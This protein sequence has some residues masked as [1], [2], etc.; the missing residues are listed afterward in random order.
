MALRNSGL[1]TMPAGFGFTGSLGSG[2]YSDPYDH[3]MRDQA[4]TSVPAPAFPAFRFE[5]KRARIDWR[6]LHGVDVN[7]IVSIPPARA[8][9]NSCST[10]SMWVA[11]VQ[12]VCGME[13][14]IL[15]KLRRVLCPCLLSDC[16]NLKPYYAQFTCALHPVIRVVLLQQ[17]D[18]DLD[19]LEKVV[20][21]VAYGDIEAEDTRHL[22]ELNFI[23]IFRLSQ[24]MIEY[25][26][27]VQDCLQGSNSWLQQ[28]R[29][30]TPSAQLR[31]FSARINRTDSQH[32]ACRPCCMPASVTYWHK[33]VC[34]ATSLSPF[35][36]D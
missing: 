12:V 4:M 15:H 7:S 17:R 1:Y 21:I 25:L 28:D 6:L 36:Q 8:H 31:P 11:N 34:L 2:L 3:P 35:V 24:M 13:W 19:T 33:A 22:T 18:I 14:Q 27:Y 30:V 23:K 32:V 5:P 20:N 29:C 16:S 10:R 9:N 26:L